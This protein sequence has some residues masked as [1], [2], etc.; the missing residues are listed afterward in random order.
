MV[1][2]KNNMGLFVGL[3]ILMLL[4]SAF[5]GEGTTASEAEAFE[6]ETK[7]NGESREVANE[8]VVQDAMNIELVIPANRKRISLLALG[9]TP[10]A[11]WS[12]SKLC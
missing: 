10:V 1:S 5:G 8:I 12:I 3:I 4:L 2:M 11:Q 6:W 9:I 7:M